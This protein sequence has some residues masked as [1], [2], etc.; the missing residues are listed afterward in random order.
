[1]TKEYHKTISDFRFCMYCVLLY[2]TTVHMGQCR[3]KSPNVVP[4]LKLD[5]HYTTW[6]TT[7]DEDWCGQQQTDPKKAEDNPPHV[8]EKEK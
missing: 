3:A 5:S 2:K 7:V 6:P 1:M 8:A 4:S